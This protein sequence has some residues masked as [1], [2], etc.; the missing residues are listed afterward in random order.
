MEPR[1]DYFSASGTSDSAACYLAQRY[2]PNVGFKRLES[3]SLVVALSTGA[4]PNVIRTTLVFSTTGRLVE[5]WRSLDGHVFV[6]EALGE[7]L[8]WHVSNIGKP[9]SAWERD[10]VD[11][12][13]HGVWG[14]NES[15]VFAFGRNNNG[16]PCSSGMEASGS[17]SLR[18]ASRSRP[19][20]A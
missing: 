13:L 6:A 5:L 7:L 18:L 20:T 12:R 3:E 9:G 17:L 11:A 16:R 10:R 15:L 19:C 1:V 2:D 4:D 14:L 8:R